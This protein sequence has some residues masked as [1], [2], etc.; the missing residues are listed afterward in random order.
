MRGFGSN[1]LPEKRAALAKDL[2]SWMG[3]APAGALGLGVGVGHP[4]ACRCT[5]LTLT[6]TLP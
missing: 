2:Y 6:L 5:T 1:L 4:Q 3:E